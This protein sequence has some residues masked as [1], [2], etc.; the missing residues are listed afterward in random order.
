MGKYLSKRQAKQGSLPSD[1]DGEVTGLLQPFPATAEYLTSPTMPDGS[2]RQSATLLVFL[3]DGRWK[4]RLLDRQEG[5]A[6]W[7]SG[8]TFQELLEA[9]EQALQDGTGD[10]RNLEGSRRK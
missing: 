9:L 2:P 1:V 4:A 3:E 8:S 10:W 6:L 5:Q 7:S